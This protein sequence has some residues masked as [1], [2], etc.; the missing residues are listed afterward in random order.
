VREA[1]AARE[2]RFLA[3]A[4]RLV[5]Q[6]AALK[7]DG[8]VVL[9]ALREGLQETGLRHELQMNPRAVEN[10]ADFAFVAQRNNSLS[11][12]GRLLVLVSLALV[13]LA[14][15]LG[16]ALKGAW[17]V[18]PFA[19]FDILVVYLA[20][21]YVEQRADDYECIAFH[22]DNIVVE[23]RHKGK[24]ERFEFNRHWVQVAF[25]EAQGGERG[26]LLLRSHGKE[27][28]LGVHLTGE[29]CAAVARQLKEHLKIR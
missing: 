27:V 19:G 23:R 1:G 22:D 26:G 10:S 25:I 29:Q 14:I 21:R 11:S 2:P 5:R 8:F 3:M 12:G 16:F 7:S 24:P 28:A 17:L 9:M 15:S 13:L 18:F 6:F 4:C 20:F